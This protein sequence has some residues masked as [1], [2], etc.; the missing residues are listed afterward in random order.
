MYRPVASS[1][2][3]HFAHRPT[4]R[5]QQPDRLPLALLR[6]APLVWISHHALQVIMTLPERSPLFPGESTRFN[7]GRCDHSFPC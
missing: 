2:G 7:A 1:I 5:Q 6:L 4:A 3:R